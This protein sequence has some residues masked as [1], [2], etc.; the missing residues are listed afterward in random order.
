MAVPFDLLSLLGMQSGVQAPQMQQ[1]ELPPVGIVDDGQNNAY[2]PNAIVVQN[3][4]PRQAAPPKVA[5]PPLYEV[6]KVDR[7]EPGPDFTKELIQRKGMFGVKGTLR[8]ILGLVGDAFLMQSGNKPMYYNQRQQEKLGDAMYG[9]AGAPD[10]QQ[11]M[12]AIERVAAMGFPEQAAEL[13]KTYQTT[14]SL[15]AARQSVIQDRNYKMLTDARNRAARYLSQADTPEKQAKALEYIGM[16][17]KQANVDVADLIGDENQ[18]S[19]AAR[20]V[21]SSGDMTINQQNM[22]DYRQQQLQQGSRRLDIAQQN[23]NA[24]TTRANRPPAGRQPRSQTELEYFKEISKIPSDQRTPDEQAFV[25]KYTGT[26]KKSA[27]GSLPSGKTREAPVAAPAR[28]YQGFT[29]R[30]K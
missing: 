2:D 11:K 14:K 7:I 10:D 15:D 16:L 3:S 19:E 28:Q 22:Q 18:M 25:K 12:A 26:N 8:D 29:V 9:Y 13:Y 21:L 20:Q 6:P 17:A 4:P 30:P 24:N 27:R 5:Q 23:A 1:Q